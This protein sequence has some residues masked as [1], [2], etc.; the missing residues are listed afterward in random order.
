MELCQVGGVVMEGGQNAFGSRRGVPPSILKV[1][2][3]QR[4]HAST[5]GTQQSVPR[6][7]VP[8]LDEAAVQVHVRLAG[9][10]LQHLVPCA[11]HKNSLVL[12]EANAEK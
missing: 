4:R 1:V 10:H 11:I 9:H 8:L 2:T 12:D 3:F 5:Q 6:A 7:D